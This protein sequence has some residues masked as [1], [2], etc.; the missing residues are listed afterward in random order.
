MTVIHNGVVVHDA[1]EF[2]GKTVHGKPAVY[3]PHE[4]AQ[5]FSLQDHNDDQPVRFRNIWIRKL[6]AAE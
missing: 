6:S 4:D 3:V 1:A 2:H 5:P